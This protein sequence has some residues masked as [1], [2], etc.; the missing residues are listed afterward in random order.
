M[1][2]KTHPL[3]QWTGLSYIKPAISPTRILSLVS[4]DRANRA[5]E[6]NIDYT[7]LNWFFL[8]DFNTGFRRIFTIFLYL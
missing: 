7:A 3:P 1:H 6:E 8:T 2:K 5:F 4:V